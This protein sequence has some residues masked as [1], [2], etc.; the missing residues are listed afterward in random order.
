MSL[1]A[2]DVEQIMMLLDASSFD[3][4]A[5]EVDGLKLEIERGGQQRTAARA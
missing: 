2:K 5:L 3:R 4:L 1:T